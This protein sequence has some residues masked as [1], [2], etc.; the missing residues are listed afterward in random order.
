M[1]APGTADGLLRQDEWLV[2]LGSRRR[3]IRRSV[4]VSGSG[5]ARS[6]LDF[7]GVTMTV[8]P[9][10]NQL[11]RGHERDVVAQEEAKRGAAG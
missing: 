11:H 3:G 10:S 2:C 5:R 9:W 1:E 7:R 8:V 4:S 6:G